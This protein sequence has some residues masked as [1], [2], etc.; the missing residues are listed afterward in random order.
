MPYIVKTTNSALAVAAQRAVD[1]RISNAHELCATRDATES[2]LAVA[3]LD[4]ARIGASMEVRQAELRADEQGIGTPWHDAED[5]C[6][7]LPESGGTV[8]P[9]PDG[10]VIEVRQVDNGRLSWIR[11]RRPCAAQGELDMSLSCAYCLKSVDTVDERGLCKDCKA[12]PDSVLKRVLG[13]LTLTNPHA[14]R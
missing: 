5:A 2:R 7:D 12:C 4:E 11:P 10:T 3:T 13:Q 6:Y 8:G 9:L 14:S 1:L